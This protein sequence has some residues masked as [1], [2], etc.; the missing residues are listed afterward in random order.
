MKLHT[1]RHSAQLQVSISSCRCYVMY[2]LLLMI[3][4][5]L[6]YSTKAVCHWLKG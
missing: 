6:T 1:V 4:T 3:K 5:I 2:E